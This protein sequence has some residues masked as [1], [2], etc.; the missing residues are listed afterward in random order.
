MV[1]VVARNF[2][3][4][5]RFASDGGS[6]S[7]FSSIH[8]VSHGSLVVALDVAR[9]FA[10]DW[11]ALL[12]TKDRLQV[13]TPLQTSVFVAS[14][15]RRDEAL[16]QCFRN[17]P[18]G[19]DMPVTEFAWHRATRDV[20]DATVR[21]E[22]RQGMAPRTA[23][24]G[25]RLAS[26]PKTAASVEVASWAELKEARRGPQWTGRQVKARLCGSSGVLDVAGG[27]SDRRLRGGKAS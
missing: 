12:D 21:E 8:D 4:D 18:D 17:L 3:V 15:T 7:L 27:L 14:S 13:G 23:G 24:S 1:L 9:L 22:V 25:G 16:V 20:A 26:A 11:A 6:R 2:M 19:L 10:N 5:G